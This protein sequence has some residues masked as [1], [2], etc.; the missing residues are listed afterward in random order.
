MTKD[1]A[2]ED[3]FLAAKNT[4]LES[5]D[6][7]A[8]LTKKL[9]AVEY[10]KQHEEACIRRYRYAMIIT[11][12]LGIICGGSMLGVIMSMPS[13]TPLFVFGI[14][15]SILLMIEQNSHLISTIL[16]SGV[17][18]YGIV[19]IVN[20]IQEISAMNESWAKRTGIASTVALSDAK[21]T[22]L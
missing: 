12:A 21:K 2:L 13:D 4:P 3:L 8:S 5:D 19:S 10:I 15:N 14:Q 1:K 22:I 7:M 17:I 6:F 18:C 9:D 11:F 16:L 20:N